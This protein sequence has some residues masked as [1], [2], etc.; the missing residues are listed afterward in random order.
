LGFI[1]NLKTVG[2]RKNRRKEKKE[3]SRGR[4][5][6]NGEKAIENS[7]LEEKFSRGG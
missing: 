7:S 5:K 3:S 1:F 2:G 6:I 4:S